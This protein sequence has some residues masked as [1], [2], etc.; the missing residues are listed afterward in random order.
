M[1]RCIGCGVKIQT[2]DPTKKGYL[3]EIILMEQGEEVYCKR[4]Y[5]IKHYNKVYDTVITDEYY[6]QNLSSIKNTK[7][8]IIYLVDILNIETSFIPNLKEIIGDN[9]ILLVINKIDVMPKTLKLKNYENYALEFTKK[10]KLNVIGTMM[11]SS[12]NKKNIGDVIEKIKR[13]RVKKDKS[14]YYKPGYKA[15]VSEVK[16]ELRFND[17]YVMGCT[18]VGKSTF[19]NALIE[20]TNPDIKERLTTSAQYHTT[21]D[22][23]KIPLDSKNYIIDTPGI[24]NK[25]S[26]C[27]YLD[28]KSQRVITPTKYI[29]PRTYQLNNDQTIFIGG[30]ARIDFFEGTSISASFYMA[31]DLY[32]HR[33]KTEKADKIFEKM[34]YQANESQTNNLL[35][36]PYSQTEV[37]NLGEYI[38]KEYAIEDDVPYDIELPGLGFVHITGNDVKVRVSY[39]KKVKV[40][41]HKS[42][43]W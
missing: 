17:C 3:P 37:T 20:H 22:M 36:P 13:L 23:I 16:R 41:V 19:I 39:P 38:S 12:L 35:V 29:K 15:G 40:S 6:Y 31:N 5:D 33:T 21:Q 7:S 1:S 26:Y 14:A 8:L 10:E 18:S 28:Y 43:I 9:P 30:L 25:D 34:N 42:F 24:I 11:I 27:A 32:L 2:T 4:C